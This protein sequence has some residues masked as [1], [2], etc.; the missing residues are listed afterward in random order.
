M[1]L[2]VAIL[3]NKVHNVNTIYDIGVNGKYIS[4][5]YKEGTNGQF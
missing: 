1:E 4:Y 5:G 2:Q 3:A